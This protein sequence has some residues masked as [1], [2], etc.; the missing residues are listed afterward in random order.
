MS[1]PQSIGLLLPIIIAP[2]PIITLLAE[3]PTP[4]GRNLSASDRVRAFQQSHCFM[5]VS[6][7]SRLRCF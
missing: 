6:A 3:Q 5:V 7:Y 4:F 2:A 1:R